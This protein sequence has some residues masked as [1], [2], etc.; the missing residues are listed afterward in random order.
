MQVDTALKPRL[1]MSSQPAHAKPAE[2]A[3]FEVGTASEQN[4]VRALPMAVSYSILRQSAEKKRIKKGLLADC[5]ESLVFKKTLYLPYLDFSYL[6]PAEKGFLFSKQPVQGQGRSVVL[7]LREI[8]LGFYPELAALT[9]QAVD[10]EYEPDS[11]VE[12]I[13]S[14][15][16]VN[17]RLDELK[18]MLF[19][20]DTRLEELSKQYDTLPK[21]APTRKDLKENIDHLRKT[22]EMRWKMFADGLKLP[23]R[24]DLEKIELLE[25]NLFYM[26]YFIVRFSSTGESRFFVWDREGK[27]NE[28]LAE[29]LARNNRFRELV[30]SYATS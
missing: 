23:S 16:L 15:V 27:E 20:Y 17:E 4:V 11:I 19:D 10:L 14:T 5:E 9:S 24:V 22:R 3:S 12:G 30:Q 18:R 7:A 21:T 26:P 29:E 13:D 28:P 25:G 1:T 2:S 6:Y 8:D